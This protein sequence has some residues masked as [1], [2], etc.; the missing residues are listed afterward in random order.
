VACAA[1]Y[2][3]AFSVPAHRFLRSWLQ[4]YGLELHHLT[5]SG[6]LHMTT[7]VTLCEALMGIEPHFK[8]WNYFI[9]ARLLQGLGT[10]VTALG[11]V[12]FFVRSG[13]EVASYFHLPTSSALN[14]WRKVWFFLRNDTDAPLPKFLG[15]RPIPQ[16]NWG[17]D[18][19][20]RDVHSLQ[21]LHEVV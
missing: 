11:G 8:L 20:Q 1:F 4:L 17:Y 18:V 5:S 2:E 19:V 7:F 12:D 15:S 13:R 14:R 21:P 9:H 10:E 6:I 16:P 3:R